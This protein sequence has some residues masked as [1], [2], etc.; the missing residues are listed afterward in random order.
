MCA[1][2]YVY[3]LVPRIAS[4]LVDAA[5]NDSSDAVRS[6]AIK[7]LVTYATTFNIAEQ[8]VS[9]VCRAWTARPIAGDVV[10]N[11]VRLAF[12]SE[13]G[14]ELLKQILERAPSRECLIKAVLEILK[15]PRAKDWLHKL[16]EWIN[17]A[18]AKATPEELGEIVSRLARLETFW[19]EE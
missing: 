7:T 13:E 14:A 12:W 6:V 8:D 2:V 3:E 16:S 5:C 17:E 18:L 9:A 15:Q 4:A 11:I 19:W 1:Y 10:E